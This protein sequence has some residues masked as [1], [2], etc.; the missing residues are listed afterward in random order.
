MARRLKGCEVTPRPV[1]FDAGR[2]PV[3]IHPDRPRSESSG[4]GPSTGLGTVRAGWT[5]QSRARASEGGGG[6]RRR[7]RSESPVACT[8][9]AGR[10]RHSWP[11]PVR[12][13]GS[14]RRRSAGAIAGPCGLHRPGGRASPLP[15]PGRWGRRVAVGGEERT[16]SESPAA[17]TVRAGGH[18]HSP[19]RADEGGGGDGAGCD[20]SHLLL[21][22]SWREGIAT[23]RPGPMRAAGAAAPVAIRVTC[24][25]HRPGGRASP[26]PCPGR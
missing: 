8:A 16:Q 6:R 7:S 26:L 23:P 18:R 1:P 2:E 12:K 14:R 22:P 15:G 13:A 21:A 19:A 9:R 20:P 11:G 10:H 4:S 5:C 25:L 3:A 24:G 17:C